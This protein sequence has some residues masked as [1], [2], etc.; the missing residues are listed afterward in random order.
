MGAVVCDVRA[1]GLRRVRTA[2]AGKQLAG[3]QL[4]P[5]QLCQLA[6]AEAVGAAGGF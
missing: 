1:L 2:M 6:E 4:R 3:K 5:E